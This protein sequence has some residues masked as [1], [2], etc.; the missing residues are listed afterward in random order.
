MTQND[1]GLKL[2]NGDISITLA[3]PDMRTPGKSLLSVV[4]PASDPENPIN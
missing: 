2:M 3:V 1:C 4:F